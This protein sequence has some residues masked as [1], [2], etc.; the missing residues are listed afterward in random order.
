MGKSKNP[1]LE[2][3][4]SHAY[5]EKVNELRKE[6]YPMLSGMKSL[7]W[8][9][10]YVADFDEYPGTVY[11]DHAGATL[12]ARSLI[13]KFSKDMMS[14][15]MGNPHSASSSSQLS[16]R[17]IEN[18][19]IRVLELFNADPAHFDVVF[20]A[21]AT[22]GIKLVMESF[23]EIPNGFWYGYHEDAHT[24]LVGVREAAMAGHRC[25]QS[26]EVERWL[27]GQDAHNVGLNESTLGLFAYPAQSNMNGSRLP[28]EWPGRLRKS[29][30]E[31]HRRVYSL[32]DAAA[33]V[34]TCPLDLSNVSQAPD[35]TVLSV[36][37][38]FGF[39]DLGTL[40]AR[41]E[42]SHIL[43]KRRYFG[44]GTV[45]MVT[46]REEQWHVRKE[47]SLHEQLEDG[48]L[49][50]H[51]ILALDSAIDVHR[52]LFGTLA[53]I[54]SH[55]SS[56][57]K[58]LYDGLTSL[59]HGNGGA[60]C[61]IYQNAGAS[62]DDSRSQG[63][64]VAF[65]LRNSQGMWANNSEV[66]KLAAVKNI[67]FRSGGLCN[68]G[69]I[70]SALGLSPWEMKR[71]FSAGQRCGN[72]RDVMNGKPTGMIRVS[73]GAMST[74]QDVTAF[75]DFLRE[76]FVDKATSGQE[77]VPDVLPL[78]GLCIESLMVFPIKSCAGWSVPHDMVWDIK[79]EG[80]AWDRE[81]C[82][83]HQ[84]SRAAL[85]QKRYPK[86]ALLK[87][88]LDFD[89]GVLRVRYHDTVFPSTPSEITVPLSSNPTHFH[90]FTDSSKHPTSRVCGDTVSAQT[91]ASP[92]ITTFF[93]DILGV[94]CY[95]AR[96]PPS[97][98]APSTRHAKAQLQKH[99]PSPRSQT[100]PGSFPQPPAPLRHPILLANESPILAISRSS[101]NR[102]N[103]QIKSQSPSGKATSADVFRANIIIAHDP[104]SPPGIEQPYV[105][106]S[107]R[108]VTTQSR[109][110]ARED[111]GESPRGA[112]T[113]LEVLG[114]C[115]RCQMVCVDQQTGERNEEPF[116]TLAKTRRVDGQV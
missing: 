44:G 45:E 97:G 92:T 77:A 81:W 65:N 34:S 2:P 67:H 37:K 3:L 87:P 58:Q 12:Y 101:L 43:G 18:V 84:G 56:L 106:D 49:P 47:D 35:F 66:E 55:T 9:Q 57:A 64:V 31:S 41:K 61:T 20:V 23:R 14:N 10:C 108:Y 28:L 88:S 96:F 75:L 63:P 115:R 51:S 11:L 105:E 85:S 60:L 15:L 38:I 99:Q 95:L 36:N 73:L 22:A 24:S 113:V 76:F 111:G 112:G 62:F 102:L 30:V 86:M 70:A 94:P 74:M 21:N 48:T 89:K 16:S 109:D 33:L 17:L 39:P 53:Q 98:S 40:I 104:S 72:E 32:L 59:R 25:F 13:E 107:W 8:N 78:P 79:P 7:Y 46:C 29:G 1:Q 116:V 110:P 83:V 69:G 71:N 4:S 27:D 80:L 6:E 26:T 100:M 19:R 42:S 103:E 68:P 90:S 114:A 50:V 93:T 52:H 54:S 5:N 82:L 91:Y